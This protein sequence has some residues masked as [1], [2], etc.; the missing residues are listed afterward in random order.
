MPPDAR[1]RLDHYLVRL[2]WARSRRAAREMLADGMVRVN[3]RVLRKGEMIGGGDAVEIAELSTLPAL[4]PDPEVKIEVLFRDSAMLVVNKPAP[5]A[6]HPLRPGE[7]GTL[8]N[9]VVA[10]FP[11]ATVA[12]DNPR[13]GGLVHRLDNGTSGALLVALTPAAFTTLREAIRA[14]RIRRDY[15]ALVIGNLK[16]SLEIENPLAH[17]PRNARRMIAVAASAPGA[18][19][20]ATS[21][22]PIRPYGD[23]TLVAARPRTGMRHQIRVHLAEAGHPIAGD[24]F[25][26]GPPLDALADGRFWLHLAEIEFRSPASG[27]VRVRSPLPRDLENALKEASRRA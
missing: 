6:C 27:P 20:A 19:T 23:F 2:G 18:R 17:D 1:E 9:G 22:E 10:A 15:Q 26:G 7:R 16:E 13:E 25:Y 8:M 3:G 4:V 12:G 5:M 24:A 21:I 11:E 14:G